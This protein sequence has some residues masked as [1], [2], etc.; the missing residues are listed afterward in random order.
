MW[1]A[2]YLCDKLRFMPWLIETIGFLVLYSTMLIAYATL[3]RPLLLLALQPEA[4]LHA[5]VQSARDA[6]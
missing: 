4:S 3:D 6:S 2:G 1:Q 5:P